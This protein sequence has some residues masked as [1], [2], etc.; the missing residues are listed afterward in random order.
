VTSG[1]DKTQRDTAQGLVAARR[2]DEGKPRVLVVDD[3]PLVTRAIAATLRDVTSLIVVAQDAEEALAHLGAQELDVVVSDVAMPG[4]SGLDLIREVRARDLDLPIIL[5]TGAPSLESAVQAVELGAFRYLQK[6]CDAQQLAGVV[7]DAFRLRRL[8]RT[9]G[10]ARGGD[11]RGELESAFRR[12][13]SSLRVVYQPIVDSATKQSAGYEALMRSGEPTLASP[14]SVLDAAEKL[15]TLH[16]LGR[17]IRNVVA[18]E[19]ER[20]APS[21]PVFV[22]VHPADL[23]DGDLY[24][25]ASPLTR[26][27]KRVV[28]ELTERSSLEGVPDVDERL[29]RLR[30]LGFRLAVDDLGAGYAGLRYFAKVKP[31]IVKIDMSLVRNVDTDPVRQRIVS[32]L[33]GLA[34]GLGMEVVAEGV[35]TEGE[36]DTAIRIGCTFVQ[37]FALARPGPPFPEVKWT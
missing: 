18:G 10:S 23:A 20:S 7:R 33:V 34:G 29:A 3:E 13:M 36:R 32:S 8:A 21:G 4:M 22:N 27:A 6:P 19:I 37:G 28:L 30:H 5:L 14:V 11:S 1:K 2:S 16:L 17:R 12:A 15:G 35:E 25:V 31:E 9:K 24:D 26:V